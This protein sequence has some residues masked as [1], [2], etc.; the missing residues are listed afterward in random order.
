MKKVLAI[1][2][3]SMLTAGMLSVSAFAENQ[4]YNVP[5]AVTA[6]T[7]DGTIGADEWQNAL[8]VPVDSDNMTWVLSASTGTIGAGSTV[9]VMYDATNIYF[10][11]EILDSTVSSSNPAAGGALNSG[12]GIQLCVYTDNAATNGDGASNLFWDFL[13]WTGDG[14]D[15]AT[16]ETF[17]H[18]SYNATT[19]DVKIASAIVGTGYTMEWAIPFA[20][21]S[22]N[23]Y[24]ATYTGAAGTQMIINVCVMDL[25]ADGNQSLGYASDGWCD[26]AA[27]DTFVLTDAVAGFIPVAEDEAP[28]AEEA[29]P[30]TDEAPATTTTAAQTSDAVIGLSALAVAAAGAALVIAKKNRK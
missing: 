14:H 13:P 28:A 1:L 9:K 26:P 16:A 7:I 24:G 2:L 29:A 17:E 19:T 20:A 15:A 6:P 18:F 27:T 22:A 5:T 11:A 21:F 3:A 23:G 25:D 30:A 10:A 4:T 12:D 8:S